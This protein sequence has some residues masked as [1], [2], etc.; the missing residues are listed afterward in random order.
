MKRQHFILLMTIAEL[1]IFFILTL[2][3]IEVVYWRAGL[4]MSKFMENIIKLFGQ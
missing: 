3:L 1:L 4:D 2:F